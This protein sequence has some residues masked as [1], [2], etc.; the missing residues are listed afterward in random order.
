MFKSA[1]LK[2]TLSYLAIITVL[3]LMFSAA[4]YHF[5]TNELYHGLNRQSQRI[6]DDF[7]GFNFNPALTP[8]RDYRTSSHHILL[9]LVYFNIIVLIAAGFASYGLARWTLQPIETSHEQQKRFTA[10]VSHEL[11]TPLTALK[12]TTEVAL[13]DTAASKPALRDALTSNLE[14]ASKLEMLVNSLLRLTR[15]EASELQGQFG[16]VDL[17][18][19]AM[20]A[21]N[22]VAER[23][24]AKKITLSNNLGKS[25]QLVHG[26][27]LSLEQLITIL[28]DNAIKYSP[29]GST[30]EI[31]PLSDNNSSGLQIVDHGQGIAAT[32]LPHIFD[33]FY[34]ADQ[35]RSSNDENGFGLGLSIA[36]M[37]TELHH[38]VLHVTSQVGKGTTISVELPK[39]Q[40]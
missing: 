5:A 35:A 2:L 22:Y 21:S 34:R 10:D 30:V 24:A 3:C 33:R 23:A 6:S 4:I 14:D 1:T 37:I 7:P 29:A 11:R 31:Q 27:S 38:G 20:A 19:N 28:L 8:D 40:A 15:L 16:S 13:M 9:N 36:Q 39:I 25:E 32:D 12:M 17:T 26:D 18:A